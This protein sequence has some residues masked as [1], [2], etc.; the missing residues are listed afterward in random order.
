MGTGGTRRAARTS[1][2]FTCSSPSRDGYWS[3]F[4]CARGR[5]VLEKTRDGPSTQRT[6]A[7]RARRA[8][9]AGSSGP[10][11]RVPPWACGW[12]TLPGSSCGSGGQA[13]DTRP[14]PRQGPPRCCGL[15]LLILCAHNF[16]A[17]RRTGLSRTDLPEDPTGGSRAIAGG[18]APGVG[19]P[20]RLLVIVLTAARLRVRLF[21]PPP[22]SVRHS[23]VP[24]TRTCHTPSAHPRKG[25]ANSSV[26]RFPNKQTNRN[27]LASPTR[28]YRRHNSHVANGGEQILKEEQNLGQEVT[29][30]DEDNENKGAWDPNPDL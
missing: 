14:V 4:P 22:C 20:R 7:R 13:V 5:N 6:P 28:I 29:C 1:L 9:A 30:R 24:R 11:D 2:P 3:W 26:A 18:R 12:P 15:T 8:D 17:N 16:A 25:S 23:G 27:L 19:F 10:T 21:S